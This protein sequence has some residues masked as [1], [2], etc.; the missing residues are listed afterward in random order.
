VNCFA[1]VIN[2]ALAG[3]DAGH[4]LLKHH[5]MLVSDEI[6]KMFSF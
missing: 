4:F 1:D 3:L 2:F 6:T 5:F